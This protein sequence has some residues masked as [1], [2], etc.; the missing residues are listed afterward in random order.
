M[1]DYPLN[2]AVIVE[3][4]HL[5]AWQAALLRRL[6][7][8]AHTQIKLVLLAEQPKVVWSLNP[9]KF[10]VFKKIRNLE[11][12]FLE[13]THPADQPVNISGLLD[14]SF[15]K[16]NSAV[17]KVEY[18][19]K[20][21][22]LVI[23]LTTKDKLPEY[24]IANT[25]YGVWYYFYNSHL[26]RSSRWAGTQ[27]FS[28]DQN[29]IISGV[30]VKSAYFKQDRYLWISYT[31]KQCLLS[32]THD[33]LLWKMLEFIPVLC[34][35]ASGFKTGKGFI[36]NR[37]L[38][39]L[40]DKLIY[41][42]N[43][44]YCALITENFLILL[45]GFFSAHL[46]RLTNKLTSYKQ[47]VLL[48]A[49]K[50]PIDHFNKTHQSKLLYAPAKGFAADPCLVEDKGEKYVFFEEYLDDKKRGRIVRAKL[51]DLESLGSKA[52]LTVVLEKEY[53]L[54]YPFVFK[55][56]DTWY[57]V[58]ESAENRSLDLYRCTQ[59]PDQWEFVKSLLTDIEAYDATL[60]Q[61]AGR[62][63]IFV[64]IRPHRSSSPNEL[65]YLFSADSLLADQWQA[66]PA[67]PIINHADKARSAGALFEKDGVIYRP[68]Q[69]CAGSYG[70]GLNLNA[71]IEWNEQTYKE[72]SVA[73][74][75]PGGRASLEGMHSISCLGNT[76]ISDGIYTRKRWRKA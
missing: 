32:K 30:M 45:L 36:Q 39:T 72:I 15:V 34:Q 21:I 63:W 43:T 70:R 38:A 69:N 73:Q 47:W 53:H 13:A 33:N 18:F 59:F 20:A 44:C 46:K 31:S 10:K 22:N 67:N 58:P 37:H 74:C 23:N 66:H 76:I 11:T 6:S 68:S 61:Y 26:E 3:D 54:S 9:I 55:E 52:K 5:P 49:E 62:W 7:A 35:Q 42:D 75:I 8:Q 48:K 1:T 4:I 25:Y 40:V 50:N 16:L 41:I 57:L 60:H 12:R 2:I 56:A 28:L 64:N 14:S 19:N 71:I 51:A 17:A 29:G 24:L 65:L 27:E